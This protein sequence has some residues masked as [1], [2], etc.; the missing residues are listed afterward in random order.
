MRIL[1]TG[2]AGYIGSHMVR[3]L[4]QKNIETVVLDSLEHGHKEAIPDSV[5]LITGNI[6]DRELLDKIFAEQSYDAVIHFAAYLS[7]EESVKDPVKYMTNNVI[8]PVSILD[9]MEQAKVK[10]FIFS[11]SAAVYGFPS[12]VPIPEDHPKNPSSPYGLSKLTFEH[13]LH[14]YSRKNTIESISLR[15][16]NACGASFDGKYGESHD[17]ETHI[18]PLAIN[19][20]LGK[21]NEFYL[22]GTDY[23][24]RDGTC[25]RDYI[26]VEDLASAH[27]AALDAL[28]NGHQT[29]VYNVATGK[30]ATNKEVVNIVKK[31]T[32][33]DFP[34]LEKPRRAGD[35]NIL[36][37]D[38]GKIINELGWQPQHSEIESIISSAWKWHESHPNGYSS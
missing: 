2:G 8:R 21:R 37:A 33:K 14:V 26:H 38:P 23:E 27:L 16:F 32:G 30:G 6:G 10:Y 11:S 12:I 31:I 4:H 24:T 7:V 22:Y 35:P 18:I 13:L 36:V 20:A 19:T 17:P 9:A 34:V 3:M 29:S 1:V 15:Y 28:M 5:R 25:E